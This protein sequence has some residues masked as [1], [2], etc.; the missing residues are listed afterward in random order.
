MI[1]LEQSDW[2]LS[3][4][5]SNLVRTQVRSFNMTTVMLVQ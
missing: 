4:S 2:H 3:F 1:Q 5:V